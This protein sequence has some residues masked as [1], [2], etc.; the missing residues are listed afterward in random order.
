MNGT[1][2]FGMRR[3]PLAAL[4]VPA[5]GILAAALV[6]SVAH[7]GSRPLLEFLLN[8]ST[9]EILQGSVAIKSVSLRPNLDIQLEGIQAA[10]HTKSRAVPLELRSVRSRGSIVR[11]FSREGGRFEF[12]GLGFQGSRH[13]GLQ[14]AGQ[15]RAW[16]QWF[17]DLRIEV[18]GL[19]LEEI[20]WVN[21][22]NLSGSRGHLKGKIRFRADAGGVIGTNADLRV[23]PPGGRL[24]AR[25]LELLKPYLPQLSVRREVETLLANQ[26]LVD[27]REASVKL[28]LAESE[29][30]KI[31]L[32][33]GIPDYNLNLN[34]NLE[35]RLD[36]KNALQDLIRL[37]GLLEL[38]E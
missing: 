19:G 25:F 8:S 26:P 35:V 11:F 38:Q 23:D 17:L 2:L 13:A 10:L 37:V 24:P 5:C 7:S 3:G 32:H 31:F 12:E 16:P 27:F 22:E 1:A 4:L 15:I 20:D 28:E 30:M 33:I 36:E 34:V 9:R 29:P 6:I 18:Q 14:G 21:P